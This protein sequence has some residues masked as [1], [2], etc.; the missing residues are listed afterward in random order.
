MIVPHQ[1]R[2]RRKKSCE[3]EL[4]LYLQD[5]LPCNDPLS[6]WK[7]KE[8]E[9]PILAQLARKFYSV[10]AT[11]APIERVFSHA[12]RILTPLRSRLLPEHFETLIFL[13]VNSCFM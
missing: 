2:N 4:L 7:L 1:V 12:G 9:Y 8:N 6:Y 10:P 11:S 5:N 13:K 3:Q